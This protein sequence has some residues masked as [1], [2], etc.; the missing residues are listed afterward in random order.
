MTA[1]VILMGLNSK[2]MGISV[3]TPP[4]PKSS[5]DLN[6]HNEVYKDDT[7][8][9]QGQFNHAEFVF[10]NGVA[11]KSTGVAVELVKVGTFCQK[12][13]QNDQN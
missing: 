1:L 6:L 3:F 2:C 7:S 11:L 12:L 13:P 9:F 8:K 4:S 10:H 5:P